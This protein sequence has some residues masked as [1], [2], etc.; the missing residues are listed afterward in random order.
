MASREDY[1]KILVGVGPAK[2]QV[3]FVA[4]P[5]VPDF[6]DPAIDIPD[7]PDMKVCIPA[8][9]GDDPVA[10]RIIPVTELGIDVPVFPVHLRIPDHIRP[11]GSPGMVS[12]FLFHRG[13]VSRS[14]M[15]TLYVLPVRCCIVPSLIGMPGIITLPGGSGISFA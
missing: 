10:G 1:R 11:P 14:A 4:W 8:W 9:N 12:L 13:M 5:V 15:S 2:V 6:M 3:V 7:F